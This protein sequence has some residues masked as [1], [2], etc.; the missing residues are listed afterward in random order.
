MEPNPLLSRIDWTH[1]Y[2][3]FAAKCRQLVERCQALDCQYFA[4][5]GFRTVREQLELWQK[6]RNR[7][8]AV[9]GPVVTYVR[10]GAHNVGVAM[11][12]T[13]DISGARGLQPSWD[14]GLYDT[15]SA[16]A[17]ALGLESGHL[18]GRRD[19]PHVQLPLSSRGVSLTALRRLYMVGGMGPVWRRLDE[20]GP[21]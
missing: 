19:S 7:A 6:G 5:S 2:P 13:R 12:F 14:V 15:L 10:F 9:M 8:G 3:P 4:T 18:W 16:E 11:D 17:V 21:W 1:V 20:V